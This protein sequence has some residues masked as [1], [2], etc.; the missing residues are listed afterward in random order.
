MQL[1]NGALVTYWLTDAALLGCVL[2]LG[3]DVPFEESG[4][5]TVQ[6]KDGAL[7]T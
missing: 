2:K 1:K 5:E 7:V 3:T 6:M 4:Q